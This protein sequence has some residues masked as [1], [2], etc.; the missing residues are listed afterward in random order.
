MTDQDKE[1]LLIR[2]HR[3]ILK[4]LKELKVD[5]FYADEDQKILIKNQIDEIQN[6]IE[7]LES[8][9]TQ[10]KFNYHTLLKKNN[11]LSVI[12]QIIVLLETGRPLSRH[13]GTIIDNFVLGKIL[14]DIGQTFESEYYLPVPNLY[15]DDTDSFNHVPLLELLKKK[16]MELNEL[17]P[18]NYLDLKTFM[19][20]FF[21]D[22]KNLI[23]DYDER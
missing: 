8:E 12:S 13:Q 17:E 2:N 4:E 3:Q 14:M 20:K 16:R 23:K 18:K 9:L 5:L 11:I 22:Y 10:I 15:Y 21:S 6:G 7:T 1:L 19:D